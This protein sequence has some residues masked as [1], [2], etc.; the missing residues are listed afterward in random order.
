MIN[1]E[2]HLAKQIKNIENGLTDTLDLSNH[3][4]SEFLKES[5]IANNLKK[6]VVSNFEEVQR[7]LKDEEA[8][9]E[10]LTML[11]TKLEATQGEPI[12]SETKNQ[13]REL[14]ES[15]MS[16]P[17]R[18]AGGMTDIPNHFFEL[19]NLEELD[20]SGN[21]IAVLP[22]NLDALSNLRSIKLNGNELTK[23]ETVNWSKLSKLENIDLRDNEIEAIPEELVQIIVANG[24][25]E[26]R[27]FYKKQK[28][29]HLAARAYELAAD[30][31]ELEVRYGIITN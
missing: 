17:K 9:V 23:L 3:H 1:K 12:S 8:F 10:K 29:T 31:R 2:Q 14:V 27:D 28:E 4:Y 15:N 18:R 21:Q 7:S 26:K 25:E 6:L 24:G 19:A 30:A 22:E 20:L 11:S 16:K 13:L 5:K